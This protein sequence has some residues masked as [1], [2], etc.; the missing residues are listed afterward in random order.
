MKDVGDFLDRIGME[1]D[2]AL[3]Y[4]YVDIDRDEVV[5]AA[6]REDGIGH[7]LASYDSHEW[8]ETITQEDG[9]YSDPF[10]LFRTN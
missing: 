3:Q 1:L 4:G 10:Y 8:E 6:V 7:W 9:N 2:E 5:T